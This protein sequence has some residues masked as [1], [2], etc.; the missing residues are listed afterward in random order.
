MESDYNDYKRTEAYWSYRFKMFWSLV[1]LGSM[2]CGGLILLHRYLV[3]VGQPGWAS[4]PLAILLVGAVLL[5][6]GVSIY[7]QRDYTKNTL[8]MG[9]KISV[10]TQEV[11][12]AADARRVEAMAKIFKM[13]VV[14]GLQQ[15]GTDAELL[16][17]P[18]EYIPIPESYEE[19]DFEPL[20]ED[21]R[22]PVDNA[23]ER[24][25]ASRPRSRI[26]QALVEAGYQ[27]DVDF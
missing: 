16:P 3:G 14:A 2:T 9:A 26:E 5:I 12:A 20:L 11:S 27:R 21:K 25:A 8:I 18:G 15:R 6:S 17:P 13:G 10:S 22:D 19:G 4:V 1:G 24:G 23:L 7:A